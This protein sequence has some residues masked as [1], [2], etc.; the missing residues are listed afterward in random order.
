[1]SRPLYHLLRLA[2]VTGLG[3][4]LTACASTGQYP[5]DSSSRYPAGHYPRSHDADRDVTVSG[6]VEVET[7][8]GRVRLYFTNDDRS[9]IHQYYR[10][11]H[12]HLPPGLAKRERLPPGLERQLRERGRLPPGLQ[13][14]PLPYQLER[15]LSR[16]PDGY[17]RMQVGAHVILIE[18]DTRLIL[19]VV[20][21]IGLD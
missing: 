17:A 12:R 1:M 18:E 7:E 5:S 2:A 4:V 8:H 11:R 9:R 14:H 13:G 20:R 19:D 6:G 3:L 15:N 21:D 16:L 10:H